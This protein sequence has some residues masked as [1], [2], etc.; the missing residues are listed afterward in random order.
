MRNFG[1]RTWLIARRAHTY[2]FILSAYF[3]WQENTPSHGACFLP[4]K[5]A[6]DTLQQPRVPV[7]R[8]H[9][10]RTIPPSR[11]RKRTVLPAPTEQIVL[12]YFTLVEYKNYTMKFQIL[13]AGTWLVVCG[14]QQM[15]KKS[16]R[17]ALAR[18]SGW[19][20]S[21]LSGSASRT[22]RTMVSRGW[23]LCFPPEDDTIPLDPGLLIQ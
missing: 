9:H 13:I 17:L 6:C 5:N 21:P 2:V 10:R 7:D 3:S 23:N 18:S 19:D 11:I 20:G 15:E 1:E 4:T 8:R 22:Q 12:C 14:Y 16:W